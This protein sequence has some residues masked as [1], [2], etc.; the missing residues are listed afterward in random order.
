M[1][2]ALEASKIQKGDVVVIRYEGPK[3]GPGMPEMLTPTSAIMGAG[4]GKDV[5]L[6]TDGRFSGGSHGFIIGHVCP[7]A[8]DGGPIALLQDGD[9][10]TID[11]GEHLLAM[12]VDDAE[13]E[14]RR[15]AWTMPPYKAT[16]GTLYK[17]I[18]NVKPASEGCVTDE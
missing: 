12:D 6:I 15:A 1:L 14:R 4:L 8:Q 11:A 2:H 7:E 3:G 10:V 16:R 9:V 13:L 5:A 18:K 17:Y